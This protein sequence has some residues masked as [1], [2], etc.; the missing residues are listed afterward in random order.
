[1]ISTRNLI[2]LKNKLINEII[3]ITCLFSSILYWLYGIGFSINFFSLSKL[4]VLWL[5]IAPPILLISPKGIEYLKIIFGGH[6]ATLKIC[7]YIIFTSIAYYSISLQNEI[8]PLDNI[9]VSR[10][11]QF[12]V[13]VA[14]YSFAVTWKPLLFITGFSALKFFNKKNENTLTLNW[15]IATLFIVYFI[16]KKLGHF[17]LYEG[18]GEPAIRAALAQLMDLIIHTSEI[19]FFRTPALIKHIKIIYF[20]TWIYLLTISLLLPQV[21]RLEYIGIRKIK[22]TKKIFKQT[23]IIWIY[24]IIIILITLFNRRSILSEP[25][26]LLSLFYFVFLKALFEE[27]CFRGVLQ[28]CFLNMLKNLKL[29]IRD[30][31]IIAIFFS[32][33]L[34][35][36]Y[37][38]PLIRLNNIGFIF[39]FGLL[40]GRIFY[41]TNSIMPGLM[42]H[43]V[44]NLILLKI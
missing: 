39:L 1:M 23:P 42:V 40:T 17:S 28:T 2:L 18:I 3:L 9:S 43:T 31:G 19:N 32:T 15:Q 26:T 41:K 33:I 35:V 27:I 7:L 25:M 13:S 22:A 30:A 5:I 14:I 34:F 38:Y 24:F 20:V 4:F 12:I 37:H 36:L 29:K 21:I 6:H 44:I 11:K 10:A 16:L 8:F